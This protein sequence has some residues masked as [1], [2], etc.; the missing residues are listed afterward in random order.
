MRG[1]LSESA[2]GLMDFLPSLRNAEAIAVGEGVS[3]P[4]RLCFDQLPEADRPLSGT[5][6]FSTA[7][8]NDDED[9]AFLDVVVER[10]RSQRR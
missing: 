8:E 4:A 3:V 1:A 10:W 2:M 9:S 5:A 7:W 6:S